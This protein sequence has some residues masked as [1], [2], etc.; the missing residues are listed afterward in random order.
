MSFLNFYH[1]IVSQAWREQHRV[2]TRL[3]VLHH[4]ALAQPALPAGNL[5]QGD[6]SELHDHPTGAGRSAAGNCGREGEA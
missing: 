2:F 5:S 4:H 3:P 6:T 1:P